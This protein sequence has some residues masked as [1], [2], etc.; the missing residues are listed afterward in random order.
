MNGKLCDSVSRIVVRIISV[1]P[2]LP[3][4][5]YEYFNRSHAILLSLTDKGKC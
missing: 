2:S 1:V 3:L 4:F 5:I